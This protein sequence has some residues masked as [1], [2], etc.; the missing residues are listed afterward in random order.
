MTTHLS[1]TPFDPQEIEQSIPDRFAQQVERH[2]DR[3][4]VRCP[5]EALTYDQLNT[6]ANAVAWRLV[7]HESTGSRVVVLVGQRASLMAAFLGVLKAGHAY[8]PLDPGHPPAL[9]ARA[10]ADADACAVVHDTETS[11]LASTLVPSSMGRVDLDALDPRRAGAAPGLDIAPGRAAYIYYTSGSTGEP[12]G[13]VD[14]HRNVLHNVRRYTNSL[15]IGAADRLSLIQSCSFSGCVSTQFAAL[16]NGASLFPFDL[17]RHGPVRLAQWM[18]EQ[19][20]TMFHAVPV[21]FRSLVEAAGRLPHLRVVRLEG[22]RA[23]WSD[24]ALFQHACGPE[25]VLVNGLGT[26]ETGLVRRFEVRQGMRIGVGPLPLGGPVEGMDVHL[27]DD[28]GREVEA[29]RVGR[30]AVRSRHLAC[31]YWRQPERTAAA[32]AD[33]GDGLREYRTGDLGCFV[34]GGS[35]EYHGRRDGSLKV[36][37]ERVETVAVERQILALGFRHAVVTVRDEP[38]EEPQLVAYLVPSEAAPPDIAAVRAALGNELPSAWIPSAFVTLAALPLT[39][40]NKVDISQLPP[41]GR[42]R[43]PLA[44]RYEAPRT[45]LEVELAALWCSLLGLESIGVHDRFLDLGGHSLLAARLLVR[46]RTRYGVELSFAAILAA[47]TIAELAP[48]IAAARGREPVA[49]RIPAGP[50]SSES[51]LSFAQRHV[52]LLEQLAPDLPLYNEASARELAGPLVM[53]ALAS[54]FVEVVGRHDALRATV[55]AAGREPLQVFH[56][57]SRAALA[58]VDLSARPADE[59]DAAA[60]RALA[61]A[62]TRRFDLER[63]PLI[64]AELVRLAEDRHV[65]IVVMHHL[66]CDAWSVAR[67][68]EEL[69]SVYSA[70]VRGVPERRRQRSVTRLADLIRW[71]AERIA[72]VL[73]SHL[74]Y[75]SRQ[76][77]GVRTEHLLPTTTAGEAHRGGQQRFTF[78]RD[79]TERVAALAMLEGATPFMVWLAA[80]E[81]ALASETGECDLSIG[82]PVGGRA[83]EDAEALIGCFANMVVLRT[84]LTG[85]PSFRDVVRRVR[86]VTLAAYAHQDAPIDHVVASLTTNRGSH[87]RALFTVAFSFQNVPVQP[88]DFHDLRTTEVEVDVP[89]A[90]I[91]LGFSLKPTVEGLRVTVEFSERLGAEWTGGLVRAWQDA[92]ARGLGDPDT[93]PLAFAPAAANVAALWGRALGLERVPHDVPFVELGGDSLAAMSVIAAAQR[94][95]GVAMSLA[96]FFRFATVREQARRL[97]RHRPVLLQSSAPSADSASQSL[98]ALS[99]GQSEIWTAVQLQPHLPVYNEPFVITMPG[100]V[101]ASALE[102]AFAVLIAGHD[103][104][105][106]AFVAGPD[107]P[108]RQIRMP[109]AFRIDVQRSDDG[110]SVI[111]ERVDAMARAPFDLEAPPLMRA[112][113]VTGARGAELFLVLH[114]LVIDGFG[115]YCVLVPQLQAAYEAILRGEHPRV[116]H[117]GARAADPPPTAEPAASNASWWS[118]LA[119]VPPL[120]LPA[121]FR[122]PGLPS[123]RGAF[124]PFSIDKRLTATLVGVSRQLATTLAGTLSAAFAVLLHR[125]SGQDA[126]TV[127][128][129]DAGRR[130]PAGDFRLG[131]HVQLLPVPVRVAPDGEFA[132]L[133]RALQE[134]LFDAIAH[135]APGPDIVRPR[136]AL[137]FEPRAGTTAGAWQIDQHRVQTGTAKFDLTLELE[138]RGEDVIGRFEYSTD[139]FAAAT[140]ERLVDTWTT[141]LESV[142]ATPRSPVATLT[143]TSEAQ[144]RHVVVDLNRTARAYARNAA[145]DGLFDAQVERSPEATALIWSSG[146]LSY[147]ELADRASAVAAR[148]VGCGVTS[149]D[150]VAVRMPRGPSFVITVLAVLKTGAAYVPIDPGYPIAR[151]QFL[152]AD[153]GARLVLIE[154]HDADFPGCQ[155][156]SF[157]ELERRPAPVS[158]APSRNG[159]GDGIA[160]VMYTSGSTGAP[161]GIAIPHRGVVRLVNGTEYLPFP[162]GDRYLFHSAVTFDASTF[163]L[164]APLLTG[165]T[166][167]LLE[168]ARPTLHELAAALTGYDVA[169]LWLTSALFNLVIDEQPE[170]LRGVRTLLTGGDIL[171]VAHVAEARRRFPGLRILNGYGPTEN[172]TFTCTHEVKDVSETV[173]SIPI[174]RPIANTRIFVVD[175]RGEPVPVGFPGELLIGG[176]GLGRE[177]LNQPRLTAERFVALAALPDEGRLYRSGDRVRWRSDDVLE[178]LGRLDRQIKI[179]GFRI[180]PAEV[181]RMLETHSLV[182]QAAVDAIEGANGKVLAAFVVPRAERPS[183]ADLRAFLMARLPAHLVPSEWAIVDRLPTNGAGKVSRVELPA[184]LSRGQDTADRRPIADPLA[185]AVAEVF[186]DV[187]GIDTVD[188]DADFFALGGHSLTASMVAFRLQERWSVAVSLRQMF[189]TPTARGLGQWLASQPAAP[190]RARASSSEP[191]LV[192]LREGSGT[193]LVIAA[194][195]AGEVSSYEQLWRMLP[196]DPDVYAFAPPDTGGPASI[197]AMA[198]WCVAAIDEGRLSPRFCL[199]G[200]SFGGLIA[201]ETARQWT[202]LGRPAPLVAVIDTGPAP[203]ERTFADLLRRLPLAAQ[204]LPHWLLEDLVRS[205]SGMVVAEAR[206]KIGRLSRRLAVG[207]WHPGQPTAQ[208]AE[209]VFDLSNVS[210]AM[211]QRIQHRLDAANRYSPG[212]YSGRITLF[213]PRARPLLHALED[214]LGWRAVV[215]GGV[216]VQIVPGNHRTMLTEPNVRILAERLAAMMAGVS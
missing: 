144:R 151:Q 13:V 17:Q 11:A 99:V 15:R 186:A 72:A 53:S 69:A 122:R 41:P 194:S 66:V 114:H 76:L 216:E 150:R 113:L 60:E 3:L 95:L 200:Y 196:D 51:P 173:R 155:V 178:F 58:F 139:V 132:T 179:R 185:R 169:T 104:L 101:D 96:D 56:V 75:W 19:R 170:L 29:G 32:F 111:R 184:L 201:F 213:R 202:E 116:P 87:G 112:L 153:A 10:I 205:S 206:R 8:V 59:R 119:S 47:P 123:G 102:E 181:E 37:G 70:R 115:L 127:A 166:C 74:A 85:D 121:D 160:Y 191:L 156:V 12:K 175:G 18:G 65:L 159:D 215:A 164:W 25:A 199:A 33:L 52:W 77:E 21:L 71:D 16:L 94:T 129:F 40:H 36:R 48:V 207:R 57:G 78:G 20:L 22:D 34:E 105:R 208:V 131:Y 24:A 90:K 106:M 193:P 6:L 192:R 143:M 88:S 120:E 148:L 135:G 100:F 81:C 124:R 38:S 49:D 162:A 64:R 55:S 9:L 145:I 92:L 146:R 168:A 14:S 197:E 5:R 45:L 68:W 73:D 4:A 180:E 28:D 177:Y 117:A 61:A 63:G 83:H 137:V 176:D 167:V 212:G 195:I 165:G 7:D 35:L 1:F 203:R 142:A 84:D 46:I 42:E 147:R 171:S 108:E 204:N 172:T 39:E 103:P 214:D 189:E 91:D 23:T 43:P 30:I 86:V 182:G 67:F 134:A 27:V 149:G 82:T 138:H 31:G 163:E 50:W 187:L 161:K 209:D 188:V 141:L 128:M 211:R 98:T 198:R 44:T 183:A 54:A 97:T 80:L 126:F 152:V 26:T 109:P 140:I 89:Y 2:G 154:R 174:G 136:T 190:D 79:I 210:G 158:A 157:E 133:V 118:L 62:A 93:K 107:G 130:D 125:W 110:E